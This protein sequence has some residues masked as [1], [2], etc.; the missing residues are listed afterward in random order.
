M[1]TPR[2]SLAEWLWQPGQDGTR[3][4]VFFLADAARDERIYPLL[5]SSW[6]DAACLYD[7]DLPLEFRRVAPYLAKLEPG[8]EETREILEL[9]WG[10]AWGVFLHAD[11]ELKELKAHFRTLLTVQDEHDKT[12]FFRFYD[13]RVLRTYLPTCTRDELERVFG[14]V[15]AF[16]LEGDE[17][18]KRLIFR[19]P[20]LRGGTE[21]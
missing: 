19:L 12:F 4:R 8:T 13:P 14:P 16:L 3:P 5:Q 15:E 20:P 18:R 11:A 17:P 6:I 1:S 9:G 21:A 7:G 2:R 10:D